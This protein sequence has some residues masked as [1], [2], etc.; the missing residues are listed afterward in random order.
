M[1]G[2]VNCVWDRYREELEAWAAA[3]MTVAA[4]ARAQAHEEEKPRERPRVAGAP[5][6][7]NGNMDDDG[8]RSEG[9]WG[10][11]GE[12]GDV[13]DGLLQGLPVGIKEFVRTEKRLGE[14]RKKR[15]KNVADER[16]DN[17]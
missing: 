8:G 5:E 3:K 7:A 15:Q 2:C 9:L 6:E 14:R 4:Q 17:D 16:D 12:E 10:E 1:S 13:A 11:G